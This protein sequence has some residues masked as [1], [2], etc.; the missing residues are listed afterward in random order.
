MVNGNNLRTGE[1]LDGNVILE[2]AISRT[3]EINLNY[4]QNSVTL[5]FSALNFFR[6]QQTFYRVR[7]TGLDDAWRVLT[8]Y[9]SGGRVDSRGLLHL[10]LVALKPGTYKVEVQASMILDKWETEPY[11]W[12]INVNEPWWRTTGVA[13]LFGLVLLTLLAINAY[14]YIKNVNMRATRNSQEHGL[15]RQIHNFAEHCGPRGSVLLE[16]VPDEYQNTDSNSLN[17]LT[18][19]FIDTM[20]KIMPT[21]LSHKVTDLTMRDLSDEAKMELRPFYQLILGNIFKNPR[22]LAKMLMLRKA[23]E[24]LKTTEKDLEEIATECGFVTPNFFIATF[25]HEYKLTPEVYRQQ[26]SLLR[27]PRS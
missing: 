2:K 19:E 4:N 25:Y 10:P 23:E 7:V 24:L 27:N 1:E 5:T 20:D 12:I 16:P 22:P 6:P 3:R 15:V 21:V 18:P 11:E 14:Y 8:N 9:N 13:V 26:N 17:A